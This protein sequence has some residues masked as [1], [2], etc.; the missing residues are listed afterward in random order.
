ME[1]KQLESYA[2]VVR[3]KSFTKAAENLYI[4][5]PTISTHIRALEEELNVRLIMRTT[6]NIEVTAEGMKLYE[7]AVNLLEL[8][9]RMVQECAA[10][11]K[12]IIHLGASTIPSAYILPEILPQYGKQNPNAF[13]VIH[14]SDSQAVVD[15][16][17]DGIFDVGL[18][19]MPTDREALACE[20]FCKDRM[21]IITPVTDHFLRLQAQP[22]TP[23]AELFKEPVILREQGSGSKKSADLFLEQMGLTDSVLNISARVNDPEAIK[24][25]VA[26]GLGI[27]IISERA[28]R[29][30]LREKRL[31]K[32]EL[33]E[34][35]NTRD[36]YVVYRRDQ[37]SRS[38]IREFVDF[39]HRFYSCGA[40][41]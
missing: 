12:N 18:I 36:L 15:G 21:I 37:G 35:S 41:G 1:F 7:Y 29:N 26:G 22:Q 9:D 8:R 14:Q 2:A 31:L 30:F 40:E 28:A 10:D 11:A 19:G 20:S 3:Y 17:T 24:N 33:P 23:I 5:Q 6:K 39:A 25:L 16:L 27:S 34:Y 13:F 32:F 4:S 38:Y